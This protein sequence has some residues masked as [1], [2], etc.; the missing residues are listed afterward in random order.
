MGY[1]LIKK[2]LV[3][4]K[5]SFYRAQN[6]YY[7]EVNNKANKSEIKKAVEKAF[8]VKVTSV[9]TLK[10]H[11]KKRRMGKSTGQTSDKKKAVVT[12]AEGQT[13]EAL[14]V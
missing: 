6:K 5:S 11:G 10:T 14:S 8:K 2:V 4:E 7:F 13:I 9:N 12:L 1:D 3:T